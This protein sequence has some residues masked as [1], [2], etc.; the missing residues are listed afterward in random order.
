MLGGG[1]GF[2]KSIAEK[3]G[4]IVGVHIIGPHASDLISEAML[5]TNW[6]AYPAELGELMHPHPTLSEVIGETF[7]DLA[8][9]PLHG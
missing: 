5:V 6:E 8:G 4:A 3:D 1:Q 9:K 7:L 2:V